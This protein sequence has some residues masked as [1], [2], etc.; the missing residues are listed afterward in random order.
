MRI[1]PRQG[2]RRGL[3]TSSHIVS[4]AK[5][6]RHGA[7]FIGEKAADVIGALEENPLFLQPLSFATKKERCAMST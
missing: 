5:G 6:R 7:F 2:R 4:K 3:L 1:R